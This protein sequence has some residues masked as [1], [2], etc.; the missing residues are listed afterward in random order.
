MAAMVWGFGFPDGSMQGTARAHNRIING[1]MCVDQRNIG[2]PQTIIYGNPLAYTV[3]RWYA[4]CMGASV[5][6]QRWPGTTYG[7][8]ASMYTYQFTGA[9]GNTGINFGQRIEA[10]NSFDLNG[11]T[12][13]LSVDL[14]NTLLTEVTWTLYY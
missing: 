11:Q 6:G 13:T 9:T 3:D 7:L 12:V 14:S 4:Y 2:A 8:D 5:T 1:G 10:M